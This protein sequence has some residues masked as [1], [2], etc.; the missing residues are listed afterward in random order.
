LRLLALDC[1]GD[2][3][4]VALASAGTVVAERGEAGARGHAERLIPLV[5]ATLGDAGWTWSSVDQLAV[6]VGPGSFTGVRVAVAAARA[7]ALA[8]DRPVVAV[9]T[10]EALATAAGALAAPVIPA[11]DA[12]RGGLYVAWPESGGALGEPRVLA[13][14]V[15]A[16]RAPSAFTAV[17]TGAAALIAAAGRGRAYA[18]AV[19]ARGV[20]AAAHAAMARGAAARPGSAVRPLYVRGADAAPRAA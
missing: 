19:E 14:A 13:P 16:E 1:S 20:V 7:L 15:A 9:T 5:D 17:G 18:H 8:L 10:L 6:A 11:I 2:L 4:S 12:R 3:R